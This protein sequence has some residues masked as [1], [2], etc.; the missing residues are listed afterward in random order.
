[1]NCEWINGHEFATWPKLREFIDFLDE[2]KC[3]NQINAMKMFWIYF[4]TQV[5]E[6]AI[7][8]NK[9][10]LGFRVDLLVV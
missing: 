1:M 8:T 6:F 2:R 7:S 4:D 10:L 3:K 9:P 5:R